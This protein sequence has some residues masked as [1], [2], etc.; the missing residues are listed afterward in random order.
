[1]STAR[2]ATVEPDDTEPVEQTKGAPDRYRAE[3][4]PH[5]RILWLFPTYRV[6]LITTHGVWRTPLDGEPGWA[7]SSLDSPPVVLGE[8]WANWRGRRLVAAAL[9]RD[10]REGQPWAR[11]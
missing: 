1:M 4:R 7:K 2:H 6:D 3:I 10:V 8:W 9:K 11:I 5:G